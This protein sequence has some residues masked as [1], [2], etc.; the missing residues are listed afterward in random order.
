MVKKVAIGIQDFGDLIKKNLFYIDKTMFIKEWWERNDNTTLIT[1]PRRFGK[2]LNLSMVEYFF[3]M[4]YA[5][6]GDIFE[7]LSIWKDEKYRQLQGSYPVISLSF[8]RIKEG[9]YK[10][11]RDKICEIVQN[12]YSKYAFVRDSDAFG[13]SDKAF[14][15]RIVTGSYSESDMTSSLHQLSRFLHLYYKKNVII[16]LDEYDTP[17]QE[18]YVK[19]Y[20]EELV[21]FTRSLFNSTFKTN[22]YLERALMTGITRVSRESIFSDLNHLKV[23]TTT[24]EEY[25][26]CLVLRK[27]RYLMQWNCLV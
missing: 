16:L 27:K 25:E 15:D 11:A 22:P 26:T 8:A 12:I 3:S 4:D 23:V 24:S 21:E 18:A 6:K 7:G 2:T 19:G 13:V 1:R 9:S 5:D 14:F 20:W 10:N 17:M